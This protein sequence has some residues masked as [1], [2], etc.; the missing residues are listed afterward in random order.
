VAPA[1][2]RGGSGR[3]CGGGSRPGLNFR[4]G[5]AGPEIQPRPAR[6]RYDGG[7]IDAAILTRVLDSAPSIV[8]AVWFGSTAAGHG[9]AGSD[10]DVAILSD[11]PPLA[12]GPTDAAGTPLAVALERAVGRPVDLIDL[13][14][15]PPLLRVEIARSGRVLVE[16]RPHAWTD[17]RVRAATDWWD[18]API[19]RRMHAAAAARVTAAARAG[20]GR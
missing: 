2:L 12:G 5:P 1:W 7:V 8:L 6:T 9:R 14:S 10:V 13:A 11:T 17:F 18:W 20:E 16:R 3:N 4:P 19:A 15:A